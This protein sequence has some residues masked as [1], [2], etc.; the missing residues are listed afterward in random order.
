MEENTLRIL[1]AI[2]KRTEHDGHF[3]SIRFGGKSH[4]E[5]MRNNILFLVVLTWLRN[6]NSTSICYHKG[7]QIEIGA[8][9]E[10]TVKQYRQ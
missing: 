3:T 5:K 9:M 4:I 6:Y 2:F 10:I 1:T 8:N 7:A